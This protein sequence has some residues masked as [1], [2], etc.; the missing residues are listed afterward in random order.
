MQSPK[1]VKCWGEG[2]GRYRQTYFAP[3]NKNRILHYR[4]ILA[5]AEKASIDTSCPNA[6]ILYL[7][8]VIN[9]KTF[10]HTQLNLSDKL[11]HVFLQN[12]K[13]FLTMYAGSRGTRIRVIHPQKL[14]YYNNYDRDFTII[15]NDVIDI[16]V[17]RMLQTLL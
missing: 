3:P 13:K 14:C 7:K 11:Y 4:F 12:L 15:N 2:E 9:S 8:E 10:F 16:S 1:I 17:I 6:I 5:L